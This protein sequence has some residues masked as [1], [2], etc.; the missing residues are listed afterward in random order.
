MIDKQALLLY[1]FFQVHCDLMG[2][3]D[4]TMLNEYDHEW[5]HWTL[6]TWLKE[7]PD[8]DWPGLRWVAT[9]AHE[10]VHPHLYA[11]TEFAHRPEFDAYFGAAWMDQ[12]HAHLHD[13]I[14]KAESKKFNKLLDVAVHEVED[15]APSWIT[16]DMIRQNLL[17]D[18]GC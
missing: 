11:G 5:C 18:V 7:Y 1:S 17:E 8:T 4:G 12:Y 14:G 9:F 13:I 6:E 10:N 2:W 16:R 3:D 15:F